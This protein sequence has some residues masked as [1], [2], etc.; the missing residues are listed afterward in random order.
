MESLL[1]SCRGM[2]NKKSINPVVLMDGYVILH[3]VF[4][5]LTICERATQWLRINMYM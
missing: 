1:F 3:E 2:K 5:N 4:K